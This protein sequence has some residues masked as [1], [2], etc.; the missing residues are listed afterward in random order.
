MKDLTRT[1][2]Q[3]TRR[4]T[5][6]YAQENNYNVK[7]VYDHY[8]TLWFDLMSEI[9]ENG[10]EG[11]YD[12][13]RSYRWITETIEGNNYNTEVIGEFEIKQTELIT[14]KTEKIYKA[15]LKHWD[16]NNSFLL[17]KKIITTN[18]KGKIFT[19]YE[20]VKRGTNTYDGLKYTNSLKG[21]QYNI[22]ELKGIQD[23]N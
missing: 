8:K 1:T 16:I 23:F 2:E 21:V 19:V 18:S 22:N 17:C 15:C 9:H 12:L 11:N 6:Q 20:V 13:E 7:A 10:K 14:E 3:E 4:A 5:I